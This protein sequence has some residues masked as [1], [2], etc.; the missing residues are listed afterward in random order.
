LGQHTYRSVGFRISAQAW[1]IRL[2]GETMTTASLPEKVESSPAALQIARAAARLFAEKGYEATSVREIVM[3]A[4]V[5]KPTLYYY[6]QSKE[7]LAHALITGSLI[8]LGS[9]LEQIV[10]HV[11][12]P[13]DCLEQVIEAHYNFCREDPDRVRFIY[14]LLFGP[15]G[16]GM[17]RELALPKA[18][19]ADWT[20]ATVRRLADARIVARARV[21]SCATA[22]RGLIVIS[23][24]DFLYHEKPLGSDLARQNVNDLLRGFADSRYIKKMGS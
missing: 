18:C 7:G 24:L 20:D 15:P 17:A 13:V 12:D 21:D 14:A 1:K 9:T 11:A 19:L 16:S 10:S 8:V 4:G 22:C 23:T 6:F 2:F 3:A 5:A